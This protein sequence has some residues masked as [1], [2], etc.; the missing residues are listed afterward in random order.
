MSSLA[1]RFLGKLALGLG[2]LVYAGL[3]IGS[4]LDR[5]SERAPQ[6]LPVVPQAMA[7]HALRG[8]SRALILAGKP[9]DA[10][11]LAEA[12][13]RNAPLNPASTGLLGAARL[14]AGDLAG[15]AGSG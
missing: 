2:C 13:V 8:Q 1:P 14:G 11:G 9:R 4:A 12:A 15:S 5:M 7:S 6:I 10:L 3:A